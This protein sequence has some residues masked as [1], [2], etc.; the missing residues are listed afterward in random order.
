MVRNRSSVAGL[1]GA[2]ARSLPPTTYLAR[3]HLERSGALRPAKDSFNI[4]CDVSQRPGL[5][6]WPSRFEHQVNSACANFEMNS[7]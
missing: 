2:A 1:A 6:E 5:K 7:A 4:L 3:T